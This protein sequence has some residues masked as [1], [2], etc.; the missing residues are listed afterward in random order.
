MLVVAAVTL[1]LVE[2]IHTVHSVLA[3]AGNHLM[4][5]AEQVVL[6]DAS[7]RGLTEHLKMGV[8]ADS[9]HFLE[10]P[11]LVVATAPIIFEDKVQQ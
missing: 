11:A 9:L 7:L 6:M 3:A 8:L 2:P 4:H 1:E 10:D 5:A